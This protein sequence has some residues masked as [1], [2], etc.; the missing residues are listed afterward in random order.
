MNQ[1]FQLIHDSIKTFSFHTL[2]QRI[3]SCNLSR[4]EENRCFT[5]KA[6]EIFSYC[7]RRAVFPTSAFRITVYP[8]FEKRKTTF[9]LFLV[10]INNRMK[11]WKY[12]IKSNCSEKCNITVKLK[13]IKV[14]NTSNSFHF[15]LF[16]VFKQNFIRSLWFVFTKTSNACNF[17]H[18]HVQNPTVQGNVMM[19]KLFREM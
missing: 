6:H 3:C 1:F 15:A 16:H 5:V 2:Y 14:F 8:Q 19:L 11:W 13:E 10:Q 4:L 9:L 12:K 18:I 17:V 7:K